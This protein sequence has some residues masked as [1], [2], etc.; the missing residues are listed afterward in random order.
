MATATAPLR[1]LLVEDDEGDALI[2]RLLLEDSATPVELTN[3][4][5]LSDALPLAEDYDCALLDLG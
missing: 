5:R 2:V 4:Q 1:V 3:V